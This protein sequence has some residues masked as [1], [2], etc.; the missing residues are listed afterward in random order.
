MR[1]PPVVLGITRLLAAFRLGL[2]TTVGKKASA[3]KSD[4]QC[5]VSGSSRSFHQ[6]DIRMQNQ[7][8]TL[9][10][11]IAFLQ[12]SRKEKREVSQCAEV[13]VHIHRAAGSAQG[14]LEVEGGSRTLGRTFEA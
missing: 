7:C 12:V 14:E 4:R 6:A 11:S 9:R 5:P 2:Y 8:R 10:S 1:D 3:A 13:Q